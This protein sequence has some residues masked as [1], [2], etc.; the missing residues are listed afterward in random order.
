[1]TESVSFDRAAD[2]YDATRGFPPGVETQVAA[3][4]AQAGALMANMRVL[5]IGVGT[6][7][8]ALPLAPLVRRYLGVDISTAMMGKLRA[9]LTDQ[10]IRLVQADATRLPLPAASMDAVVAVHV[11]HLIADPAAALRDVARVL[12]P[13]ARL[14]HGWNRAS[15]GETLRDVFNRAAGVDEKPKWFSRGV[16]DA[17]GWRADGDPVEIVFTGQRTA[18]DFLD[19][20]RGRIWSSCWRMSDEA[21]RVGLATLEAY[22]EENHLDLDAPSDFESGFVVQPYLPPA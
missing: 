16:L 7:R 1:M 9:R 11:F 14:L 6:G 21:Y 12:R 4:F 18:R 20:V 15:D 8:I 2:Y 22:I 19:G 5:E 13:G 3:A 10:P 17:N